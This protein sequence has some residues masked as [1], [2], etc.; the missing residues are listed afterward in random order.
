MDSGSKLPGFVPATNCV[1]L[2]KFLDLSLVLFI[3]MQILDNNSSYL[4]IN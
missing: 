2:D 4:L 1:N 3:H